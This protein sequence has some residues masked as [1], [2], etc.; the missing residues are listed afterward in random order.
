MDRLQRAKKSANISAD[1]PKR[2]GRR[3][4]TIRGPI[5]VQCGDHG[6]ERGLHAIVE[7]VMAWPHVDAGPLPIGSANFLSLRLAEDFPVQDSSVFISGREFGRVLLGSPTIYL[8]L[9][10]EWA[11]W[12]I[13]RGWA[14]PHFL[15][16]FGVM[17]PGVMVVYTPRDEYEVA[18][19]RSLVSVSYDFS[20]NAN[21]YESAETNLKAYDLAALKAA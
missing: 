10:L 17:P 14:E 9:P 3:P 11:H 1:L 7:Q 21:K 19:C 2:Q 18:V 8:A 4:I 16:S 12:A 15:S 20:L 13:V 6:D 5:H